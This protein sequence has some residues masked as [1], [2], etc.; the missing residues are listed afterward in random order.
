MQ[1]LMHVLGDPQTQ[2][3]VIHLTGTNGKGSVGEMITLL[4][5]EHGLSVGT[6]SSP[7]LQRVNERLRW[8][9]DRLLDV[10][11]GGGVFGR[12]SGRPGGAITDEELG[13]VVGAVAEAEALAGVRPSY[14]EILTASA[15]VWFAELPVDVAVI[16]VGLLGRYDATNVVDGDVAVVTNIGPDHT[17]FAGDWRVAIAEEKVG[18]VKPESF[19]VLGEPDPELRPIFERA[20]GERLWVRGEDFDVVADRGAVGGRLLDLRTP[21]QVITDVFVPVHGEHQSD[22]A[23]LAVAAVEAFFAR[24]LDVDVVRAAFARLHLPARFEIV[25]RSPL[26]ILDAAHNPGGAAAVRRTLDEEFDIEGRLILVVGLLQG[27]DPG[28]MLEELGAR[29]ADLVVCCTPDSPRALPAEALAGVCRSLGLAVEVWP[30]VAAAVDRAEEEADDR[31]VVLVT[32]SVYVA[33]AARGALGLPP[34]GS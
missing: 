3:P 1:R 5:E 10:D 13:R 26:V 19:L 24:P 14:F 17:D 27:R 25:R 23:A 31:D 2:Y 30:D 34:P 16:E 32:G 22:N 21:G 4:L 28:A 29:R 33:G 7:H 20:A 18:I 11:G 8:T 9:G 6:Y 12:R 15:L